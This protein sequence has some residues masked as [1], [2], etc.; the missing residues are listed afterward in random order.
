VQINPKADVITITRAEYRTGTGEWRV[1]G[2]VQVLT[3][4]TVKVHIGNTLNGTLLGTSS[5]DAL[6]AWSVR[7]AGP[8]PDGT[9]TVSIESTRGGVL[10]GVPVNVRN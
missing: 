3:G 4:N 5:P 1:E 7:L 10:L 2:T 9:R 6:G 8:P